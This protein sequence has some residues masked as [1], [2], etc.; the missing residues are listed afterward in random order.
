MT[1]GS[2]FFF[3][4][5]AVLLLWATIAY[6]RLVGLRNACR[7]AFERIDAPLK[8]RH[9]LLPEV[10]AVIEMLGLPQRQRLSMAQAARHNAISARAWA[11]TQ[12]VEAHAMHRL[13]AAESALSAGLDTVW[14]ATDA[15]EL[16][17]RDARLAALRERLLEV[18]T[19]IDSARRGFNATVDDYNRE[20]NRLPT[21]W[22][23]VAA[24]FQRSESL[25]ATAVSRPG[26]SPARATA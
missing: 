13:D 17:S 8:Q 24:G 12:G 21:R 2:L 11:A 18:E 4:S 16:A 5:A 9:D 14:A 3:L 6:N 7:T 19:R 15:H 20:L 1:V 10:F 26:L 25:R 22:L 23:A